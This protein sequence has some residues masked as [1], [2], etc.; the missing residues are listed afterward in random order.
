L[1]ATAITIVLFTLV[2]ALVWSRNKRRV[3]PQP[4]LHT[5]YVY[6][7]SFRDRVAGFRR[8]VLTDPYL[9]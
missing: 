9:D 7:H 8:G 5:A 6:A 4:P 2:A 1:V 3:I